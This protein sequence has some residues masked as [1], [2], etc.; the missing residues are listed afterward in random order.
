ML[1]YLFQQQITRKTKSPLR[2]RPDGEYKKD[3]R[4]YLKASLT[5][6]AALG[7]PLILFAMLALLVPMGMMDTDRIMQEKCESA[8]KEIS[9][10]M[11]TI[12]ETGNSE[13]LNDYLSNGMVLDITDD[14]V[15]VR[16]P[17]TYKFPI[18]V[19]NLQGLTQE[20]VASRRGWV[21]K[22]GSKDQDGNRLSDDEWVYIGKNSTRYHISASCHYLSNEWSTTVVGSDMKA[23]GRKACDRCCNNISIGQTV[24]ITESGEKYHADKTCS[25]MKAYPKMV[26][27]SEVEHMGCCSYCGGK[28]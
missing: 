14:V 11:Y 13:M 20:A 19:L 21:G 6:E 12:N 7:L 8:A 23:L 5:V 15:T 2:V 17:Y 22:D 16:L 18:K 28:N 24:Y 3:R 26:R 4:V 1:S 9:K 10:H 27:K 25:A